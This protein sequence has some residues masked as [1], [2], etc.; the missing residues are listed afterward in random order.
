MIRLAAAFAVA[1]SVA[2]ACLAE[3]I[4]QSGTAG[5]SGTN[6]APGDPGEN[7]GNGGAGGDSSLTRN[8]TDVDN[9][10]VTFGGR[11]GVGGEG[12]AGVDT[13]APPGANG[14]NGGN[15][16]DG[17]NGSV[18]VTVNIPDSTTTAF[19]TNVPATGGDAGQPGGGGRPAAT[20]GTPGAKGRF[21]RGGSADATLTA[22]SAASATAPRGRVAANA[23]AG[24]GLPGGRATARA[25]GAGT[26]HLDVNARAAGG[27]G[28][29]G[30]SGDA[31]ATAISTALG[32]DSRALADA[33][34]S[35]WADFD[36]TGAKPTYGTTDARA[37]SSIGRLFATTLS[38]PNISGTATTTGLANGGSAWSRTVVYGP[39]PTLAST[40]G[41]TSAA[42]VTAGPDDADVAAAL[43]ANPEVGAG[44][45]HVGWDKGM[46]AL[47]AVGSGP[48]TG[49]RFE[50]V[51]AY[52]LGITFTAHDYSP[53]HFGLLDAEAVGGGLRDG[54]TLRFRVTAGGENIDAITYVDET[55]TD[56]ASAV[57]YFDDHLLTIP[58]RPADLSHQLLVVTLNYTGDTAG[59]GFRALMIADRV[60]IPEPTA[61]APLALAA[62]ALLRRR[63]RAAR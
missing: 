56:A 48:S 11:G 33:V 60:F 7:G 54:A 49:S 59:D 10:F 28:F 51:S 38:G 32:S 16:G 21:G 47:S 1:A 52:T 46:F 30:R 15:G 29:G 40:A 53:F 8:A 19:V 13:A 25:T 36:N 14:G 43:A 4:F 12:G 63:R 20:G 17:G 34:S 9:N 50:P 55:F 27:S 39:A 24:N 41:L 22:N 31:S 61:L 3:E 18:N 35:G 37:T 23:F 5:Q 26:G 45:T 42:L 6:G 58:T 62:T 2:T 57:A 44:M